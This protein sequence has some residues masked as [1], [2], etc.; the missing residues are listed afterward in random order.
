MYNTKDLGVVINE[1][2]QAIATYQLTDLIP[3]RKD[4]WQ[5]FALDL[6]VVASKLRIKARASA[7]SAGHT[8]ATN[9]F[10]GVIELTTSDYYEITL[11]SSAYDLE[12][13]WETT[14]VVNTTKVTFMLTREQ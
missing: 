6:T 5:R 9:A 2:N 8:N 4:R 12:L 10:F 14:N 7:A 13:E 3:M 11:P 1:S